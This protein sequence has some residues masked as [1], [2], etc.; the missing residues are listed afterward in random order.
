MSVSE[1]EAERLHEVSGIALHNVHRHDVVVVGSGLAALEC[2]LESSRVAD[3]AVVSKIFPTRSHSGA[4]QGGIA[5]SLA[6]EEE[7]HQEWHMFDTVKGGDYLGDQDAIEIL[8]R[9]ARDVVYQLEHLGVPFS[10]N[11]QGRIAQRKFGGHTKDFGRGGPVL[12]A[13]YAADRTGHALLHTLWHQCIK[14]QVRFYAEYM[15]LSLII[16][17]GRCLG[18]VALNILD[19]TVHVFQSRAVMLGTGG[20]ARV[21]RITSNSWANTGD[22]LSLALR[23]GLPLEDMEFVQFHPTGLFEHGILLSEGARGEGGHLLNGEGRRFME[24][25][26]KDKMELAPRDVVARAIQ[27]EI[28]AGRGI[29]GQAC[30]YLDL[31]HLGRALIDE[32]LPQI[33][34]IAQKFMGIDATKHPV[35][36]QPTAHYSMGGI[37]VSVNA[38]VLQDGKD[39]AVKGLY[40]AGE[41]SCVSVHGA[42]RL[43]TNSLLEACLYGRRAGQSV[44][45]YLAG[46][47]EM[48][49]LP[50]DAANPVLERLRRLQGS[51]GGERVAS[52]RQELQETMHRHCAV[53]RDAQSL[54]EGLKQVRSLQRR[55]EQVKLDGEGKCFNTEVVEALEF[56]HMLDFVELIVAGAL[57]RTESRGAQSR[58]D[59]PDR[60]DDNWLKH[61]L[62]WRGEDG[63]RFDYKPVVIGRFAPKAREY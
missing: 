1:R 8:A 20:Y 12:R 34:E 61:T 27:M 56:G 35:P 53:F 30:V 45:R 44:V 2:A 46:G 5:A 40:A 3:V 36:I 4:A 54:E 47:V 59:Y 15:V 29:D 55:Y 48:P 13:C 23:A 62:A 21:Y 60:D 17:E 43:G 50:V 25:Y 22:G 32:R 41:C 11:R 19:S 57:N 33:T 24:D 14:S 38:E 37:P 7:D 18:V 49:T 16:R 26:A 52:L 9:E 31:R 42:N 51:Q 39:R 58:T 6:N 28:D 10:R 63:V